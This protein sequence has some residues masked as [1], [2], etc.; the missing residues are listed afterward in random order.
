MRHAV[1]SIQGKLALCPGEK[2]RISFAL[3]WECEM[4]RAVADLLIIMTQDPVCIE[5]KEIKR[6]N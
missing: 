1:G 3:E 4:L 5:T 2:W 6:A